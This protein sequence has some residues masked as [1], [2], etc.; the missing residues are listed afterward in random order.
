M[1][2]SDELRDRILQGYDADTRWSRVRRQLQE[3]DADPMIPSLPY[4]IE[5]GFLYSIQDD[6]SH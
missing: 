3:E 6:G 2:M 5:D 1:H 4:L